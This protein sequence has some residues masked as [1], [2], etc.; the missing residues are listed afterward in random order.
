MSRPSSP[1]PGAPWLDAVEADLGV[2]I[3][4]HVRVAGGDIGDSHRV[5][6]A[7]GER[8]FVKSYA[9]APP[10]IAEAEAR[11]LAWLDEAEAIRVA[12]VRGFGADW[13][14]LDWIDSARPGPD[15]SEQLG[16][17]LAK[18]HASGAPRF[19][20]ETDNWIG[21]LTQTN[22]PVADWAEFYAT[23]RIEP[24]HHRARDAGT[25][26]AEI[27]RRLDRL[28]E[29]L[30]G[31]IGPEEPPARLHGDL[32]GGNV[33]CDEAGAPCLIDP[34]VYGG[35][36]EVDLAMMQLFGGFAPEVFRAYQRERPLAPGAAERVALYQVY[37]LLVHV[38]LFGAGYV[39]RL[40][41]ALEAALDGAASRT[42]GSEA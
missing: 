7:G 11:G 36:R 14:A 26:P 18:L 25:L 34:A 37:P 24:L 12:R 8:L 30:P 3:T 10:G 13:L 19:G 20:F 16:R 39:T 9:T 35:H 28:L 17:A 27:D 2:R 32:W 23:H 15:Y 29:A 5:E 22:T 33:L 31:L 41:G 42:T 38:C 4:S 40:A 6:V 1:R 21:P